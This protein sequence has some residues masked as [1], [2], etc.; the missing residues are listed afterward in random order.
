[1]PCLCLCE[2]NDTR[3]TSGNWQMLFRSILQ[4]LKYWQNNNA[5]WKRNNREM[6]DDKHRAISRTARVHV[7]AGE[8]FYIGIHKVQDQRHHTF[9][10]LTAWPL[11]RSSSFWC[12]RFLKRSL[13]K[14]EVQSH[15]LQIEVDTKSCT[16]DFYP[17]RRPYCSWWRISVNS[18]SS[19]SISA[20]FPISFCTSPSTSSFSSSLS[21]SLSS[22]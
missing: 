7:K 10:F 12:F 13:Q 6:S 11:R 20:S 22:L 16:H 21:S 8:D 17:L 15:K 9:W 18:L 4:H 3:T 14:K 19:S 5:K 2:E 1:M